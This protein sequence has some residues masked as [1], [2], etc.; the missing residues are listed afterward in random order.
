MCGGKGEVVVKEGEK[1]VEE[2]K[3]AV[4]V[5]RVKEGMGLGGEGALEEREGVGVAWTVASGRAWMVDGRMVG[6]GAARTARV[7]ARGVAI[8]MCC[9]LQMSSMR[10]WTEL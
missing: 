9:F 8:V 4:G 1:K 6:F 2:G 5:G 3:E 10:Y 7:K